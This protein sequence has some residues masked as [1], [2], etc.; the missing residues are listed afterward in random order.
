MEIVLMLEG[1]S[2]DAETTRAMGEA[3]DDACRSLQ[4]FGTR[5][6]VREIIAR[7]II[8]AAKNGEQNRARLYEHALLAFD[9]SVLVVSA[10][11]EFPV[12]AYDS[13]TQKA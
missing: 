10:G 4:E 6:T 9:V 8:E 11:R 13:V 3:F 7:R 1:G 5:I 2:F 12:S